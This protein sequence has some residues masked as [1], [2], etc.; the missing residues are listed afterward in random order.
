MNNFFKIHVRWAL[1]IPIAS[2]LPFADAQ[3]VT[4]TNA[5]VYTNVAPA[6]A[7]KV[8]FKLWGAGGGGS[9]IPGPSFPI[10]GNGGGGAFSSVTLDAQ[11]GDTFVIV[12]GQRGAV[13]GAS[14]GG[15]G[16]GNT[17]G[18]PPG[19]FNGSNTNRAQGG[20]ASSVFFVTNNLLAMKAV[21]GGGGGAGI[22][23]FGGG[24]GEPGQSH[25]PAIGGAPGQNGAGGIG[26]SSGGNYNSNAITTGIVALN[27]AGGNGG[28][29]LL[30][31]G[32]GGGGYGGG[33]GG[34]GDPSS[35]GGG[36]GGGSYGTIVTNGSSYIPGNT[37]DANYIGT[38]G[39]GGLAGV[40]NSTGSD[41]LA[42]ATWIYDS[43]PVTY[44]NA[45]VYTNVAPAGV[46]KVT[47]KLWGA[48][49]GGGAFSFLGPVNGGGG[50]FSSVTLDAQPGDQFVIVVGQRGAFSGTSLGGT[51]SGNTQGGPPGFFEGSNTNRSQGGQGSSVFFMTNNLL[52]MR[53]VAGAGGGA[54][55]G[56]SGGA[57]GER[58]QDYSPAIG[59]EPGTNGTGGLGVGGGNGVDYNTDAITTGISAL[60]QAGGHGGMG[61]LYSG[62]GGGGYGG[63]A[64]GSGDPGGGH[65]GGGGGGGSYGTIVT[66]GNGH[67]PGNNNDG[68]YIGTAGEGGALEANGSDGL[69][70]V[71][72]IYGNPPAP[73]FLTPARLGDGSFRLSFTNVS[74]AA[75]TA[76][77]TTNIATSSNWTSLGSATEISPGQ[78]QFTDT[79]ATNLPRRFYQIRSP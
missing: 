17:E 19:T 63:G 59:G 27:Q 70:V 20:Q 60:N 61:Q 42:V 30:N 52:V 41:G 54:G 25:P 24:G 36:G 57:G 18:G 35:A 1:A 10:I 78:F 37:A 3:T 44:T 73:T 7:N 68:N 75:F 21:A 14:L 71:L 48:G 76:F 43:P 50:A 51:G 22:G 45:G 16:S 79:Q 4:Y 39:Q 72:W 12:V 74:G 64:G 34:S 49:G 32:G 5:G 29:G 13:S 53:A 58:G 28:N 38:A 40:N 9:F 47:F 15:A 69:A 55:F 46:K 77:A 6:G 65:G 11:P 62:G 67:I 23:A 33:A 26:Q 2:L 56:A 66:N 8:T 31:S